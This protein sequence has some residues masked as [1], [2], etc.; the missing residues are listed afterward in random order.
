MWKTRI[1]YS[2]VTFHSSSIPG[3]WSFFILISVSVFQSNFRTTW[4][5][6]R[7]QGEP[8]PSI[9]FQMKLMIDTRAQ[10]VSVWIIRKTCCVNHDETLGKDGFLNDYAQVVLVWCFIIHSS[11]KCVFVPLKTLLSVNEIIV[12][13]SW[14]STTLQDSKTLTGYT[15]HTMSCTTVPSKCLDQKY[16]KTRFLCWCFLMVFK[17]ILDMHLDWDF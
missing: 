17:L 6:Q 3:L 8:K 12:R 5:F 11:W 2:L 13:H 9:S 1:P 4:G 14:D 16:K 15:S 7:F 10:R